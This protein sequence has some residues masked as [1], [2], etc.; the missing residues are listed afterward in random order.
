MPKAVK[1]PADYILPL[2]I[3]GMQGRMLRMPP[4]KNKPREVLFI[5][6]HHASLER[7]FGVA[8]LLNKHGGVTVPDLP[9]FGGMEAFY[10][11]GKTADL[12]NFAD[13]LAT[14][15]KLRFRNKRFIIAGYSLA[16]P[17][18]TR[19]LQKYPELSKKIDMVVSI[20]GFTHK[21][22]FN[23]S[24]KRY[25][26]YRVGTKLFSR[27]LP[28]ALYKHLVLRP[29]FIRYIYRHLFNAKQKFIGKEGE[30]LQKAIDMEVTLW[31]N[32]DPR[33]YMATAVMMF[34]LD[35]PNRGHI[36]MPI[37]H[38][39]VVDDHYF[40][41]LRVEQHMR[42]IYSDFIHGIIKTPT[43][44]PSIIADAKEASFFV[45]KDFIRAMEKIR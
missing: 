41:N 31:R 33:T 3:N 29:I 45:P 19:M 35:L 27:R 22:D 16:M 42:M 6:G 43:H 4:P 26:I 9:G 18:V 7:Y 20:A 21:D 25:L 5:Y 28:A 34:N 1:N 38:A 39:G 10:K 37:Y 12:E 23:F 8:E 2:N 36:S 11:I 32:N 24:K 15:I 44:A 40:N 13:Y 17:I 30:D 14:F